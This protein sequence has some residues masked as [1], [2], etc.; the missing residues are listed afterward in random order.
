MKS[1]SSR[2]LSRKLLQLHRWFGLFSAIL[3]LCLSITGIALEHTEDFKL[4][5][6]FISTPS[7]IRLYGLKADESIHYA[8]GTNT[9]SQNNETLY[10]NGESIKKNVPPLCG[11]LQHGQLI[12]VCHSKG[13]DLFN[14]TGQP[15]ESLTAGLSLPEPITAFGTI[16]K[17]PVAMGETGI[18]RMDEQWLSW[19]AISETDAD[20]LIPITPTNVAKTLEQKI[21]Q[22]ALSREITWERFLLDIHA[23]RFAGRWGIYLMDLAALALIYLAC[24]GLWVW[25][26]RSKPKKKT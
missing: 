17:I 18:W 21:Q 14:L 1:K 9:V 5:Q 6:Q 20:D 22:H 10:L 24:S 8:A 25:F 15:I 3:V 16:Q 13:I 23:G 11:A 4:D 26:S 19:T 2:R 12:A 7:I